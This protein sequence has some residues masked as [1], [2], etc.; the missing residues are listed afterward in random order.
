VSMLREGL[1][2]DRAV[3]DPCRAGRQHFRDVLSALAE[4]TALLD[5]QPR[6]PLAGRLTSAE[7]AAAAGVAASSES[8]TTKGRRA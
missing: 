7:K 1:S 5:E 4:D 2:A 8:R 6:H 3:I